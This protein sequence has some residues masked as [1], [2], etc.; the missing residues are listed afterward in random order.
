MDKTM[1]DK[2][3]YTPVDAIQN[4]SFYRLVVKRLDTQLNESTNKNSL[5]FPKVVRPTN[6]KKLL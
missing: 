5:K 1:A 2:L 6:K 3:M 4:Y